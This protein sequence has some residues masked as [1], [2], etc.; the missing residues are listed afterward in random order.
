M[1]RIWQSKIIKH[2]YVSVGMGDIKEGRKEGQVEHG[3]PYKTKTGLA[4]EQAI[5]I[6]IRKTENSPLFI[7]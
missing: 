3:E 6:G 2:V 1:L 4:E 7:H 5:K